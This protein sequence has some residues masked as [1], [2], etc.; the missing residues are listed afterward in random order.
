MRFRNKLVDYLCDWVMGS[1]HHMNISE[2]HLITN[3]AR[4]LDQACMTAVAALLEGLPLQPE[5]TDR[6]DMM[7]AKSQ[8]FAKLV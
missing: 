1:S 6:G 7:E 5:D 3:G 2:H 4:D 8:L